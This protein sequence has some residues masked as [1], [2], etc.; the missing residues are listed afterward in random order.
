MLIKAIQDGGGLMFYPAAIAL[1]SIGAEARAA[2]P[3]LL[4]RSKGAGNEVMQRY[5]NMTLHEID[6]ETY[7]AVEKF[8]SGY[9]QYAQ[10]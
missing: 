4:K 6:P 2:I 7:T 3:E 8:N 5:A 1:G 9:T 10:E